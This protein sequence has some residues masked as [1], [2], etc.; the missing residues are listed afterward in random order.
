MLTIVRLQRLKGID[1]SEDL[2]ID[3]RVILELILRKKVVRRM[4][5]MWFRIGTSGGLL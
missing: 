1:H 2:R 3:G 5:W 4:G